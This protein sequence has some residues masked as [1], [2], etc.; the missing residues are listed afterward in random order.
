MVHL[1]TPGDDGPRTLLTLDP[2]LLRTKD[3]RSGLEKMLGGLD[4]WGIDG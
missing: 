1:Q 2:D 3:D 4:G